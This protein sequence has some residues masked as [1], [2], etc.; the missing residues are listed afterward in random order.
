MQMRVMSLVY[1]NT[2]YRNLLAK[3]STP[4]DGG[5]APLICTG[6]EFIVPQ[7]SSSRFAARAKDDG[8]VIE[9]DPN[10]TTTVQYKDGSK[11]VFD[12]L[13]RM[14]REPLCA[15]YQKWYSKNFSD[16]K[17]SKLI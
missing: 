10:K 2:M 13:P 16:Q 9:Y 17:I 11:E 6:A 1:V 14:S 7:L 8:K 12:T 3:Q 4:T 15:L 5:E